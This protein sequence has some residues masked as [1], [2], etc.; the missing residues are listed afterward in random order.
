M[1]L[2]TKGVGYDG[3]VKDKVKGNG[4]PVGIVR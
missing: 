3:I 1:E 4:T 2:K